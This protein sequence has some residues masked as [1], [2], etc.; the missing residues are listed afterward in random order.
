MLVGT[1]MQSDG[2]FVYAAKEATS[3]EQFMDPPYAYDV[4]LIRVAVPFQFNERVQPIGL[5]SE[6]VPENTELLVTGRENFY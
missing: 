2:G 6:I 4:A 5:S 3:H 1:N